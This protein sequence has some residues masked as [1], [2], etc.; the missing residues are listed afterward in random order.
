MGW[1]AVDADK[2]MTQRK[3][4]M[5]VITLPI[6]LLILLGGNLPQPKIVASA[7]PIEVPS[8]T[9][10][11]GPRTGHCLV[12][13]EH[14]RK[15]I[16]LDGYQ[17]PHQP[18]LGEVWSWDG[19][20]WELIPGSG[21]TA[22]SVSAAVYDSRRKR[23]VLFGGL[24][25]KG[26]QDPGGDTWEWDGKVWRKMAGSSVGT[27]DHHAM[28]YD[29]ARG[30]TVMFGGQKSDRSWPTDTW[31][32][33]GVKWRQVATQGPG[34]RGHFAMVY[35]N[36]RKEV[37]LFGG[38]DERG[39]AYN[40][41]W[42]WDGKTWRKVSETGPPPRSRHRLAFDSRAGVVVL[43][44]GQGVKATPESDANFLADTWT[45]DGKQWTEIKVTGP[46]NRYMPAMAYDAARGKT[47]LYGGATYSRSKG[48]QN[49][50][51]TWEWDGQQWRQIK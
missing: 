1:Q 12:Y 13:D 22:R 5:K 8:E 49:F 38:G 3:E 44:G 21:P 35:D 50:D 9:A 42:T 31:E 46:G 23:I 24:G 32:W 15:V 39:K 17:P 36:R 26:I 10:K 29:A 11:P 19:K 7:S 48:G 27:R 45:W 34:S 37:V 16:L 4:V 6:V 25:Y 47:V 40:D 41:T 14:L 33:D 43:Y 20:Q 28:A 30:K 18:E 51:D 2:V